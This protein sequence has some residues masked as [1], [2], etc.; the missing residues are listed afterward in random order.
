[1]KRDLRLLSRAKR[2]GN[3]TNY[4]LWQG[5]TSARKSSPSL[6]PDRW[7]EQCWR[8]SNR[9]RQQETVCWCRTVFETADPWKRLSPVSGTER[10]REWKWRSSPSREWPPTRRQKQAPTS[11][12]RASLSSTNIHQPKHRRFETQNKVLA[13]KRN[14]FYKTSSTWG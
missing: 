14:F 9:W 12:T 2:A 3:R 13:S 11:C 10:T 5:Q 4:F 8:W 7:R 1:M 6:S